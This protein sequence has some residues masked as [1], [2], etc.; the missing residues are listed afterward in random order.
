MPIIFYTAQSQNFKI[1]NR[2]FFSV[3]LPQSYL[4]KS[5]S[6]S[7][8]KVYSI[9]L[10]HMYILCTAPQLH[11]KVE[12]E[13]TLPFHTVFLSRVERQMSY[14]SKCPKSKSGENWDYKVNYSAPHPSPILSTKHSNSFPQFLRLLGRK[15]KKLHI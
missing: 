10:T 4:P 11:I 14:A 1:L 12:S 6:S 15:Y 3:C 13:C 9:V 7:H 8:K 5:S 2:F